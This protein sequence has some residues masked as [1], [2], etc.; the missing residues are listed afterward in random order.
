M[1]KKLDLAVSVLNGA[2]GDYLQRTGNGLATRMAW[3]DRGSRAPSPRVVVL[4]HGLMCSETVWDFPGGGDYGTWLERDLGY[5]PLYVR[6]NSG[7]PIAENGAALSHLLEALLDGHP[8]PIEELVLLGYSMGGLVVRAACHA[9]TESGAR[10]LP[11]ARRCV[12]VGT[13][14][15]GAP[16]ERFGR[17]LSRVLSQVDDPYTQLA[18]QLAELRSLGVKDLGD[19]AHPVPLLPGLSHYLVAGTL[20]REPWL[21][22]LFGDAL[23]PVPSATDGHADAL[24]TLPLPREHIRIVPAVG[25]VGLAHHMEVYQHIRTWLT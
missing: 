2:I 8:L 12:Y 5:T 6:Y 21:T 25:H 17:V 1:G 7:L 24:G 3:I 14:H 18:H 19:G 15:R 16:L 20:S 10:W 22:A 4:V 9:A 11:R 13:P 23:V